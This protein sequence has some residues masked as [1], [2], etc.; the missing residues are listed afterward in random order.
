MGHVASTKGL[1]DADFDAESGT[2]SRLNNHGYSG[3]LKEESTGEECPICTEDILLRDLA[4]LDPCNH[5]FHQECI[6][7]WLE[8][9]S[10]CPN[11][12][13]EV[14]Q[15]IFNYKRCSLLEMDSTSRSQE[16][17]DEDEVDDDDDDDDDLNLELPL[18]SRAIQRQETQTEDE[19]E[20]DSI[21]ST[22]THTLDDFE[23]PVPVHVIIGEEVV[24]EDW[25]DL[26]E[27][28]DSQGHSGP[29]RVNIKISDDDWIYFSFYSKC[30]EILMQCTDPEL[31]WQI[32]HQDQHIATVPP[33][34]QLTLRGYF[35][36]HMEEIVI[37]ANG[38]NFPLKD[39]FE[40]QE[41]LKPSASYFD[42]QVIDIARHERIQMFMDYLRNHL[43][44]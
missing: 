40:F 8:D 5:E 28:R 31:T 14:V 11:C 27:L 20:G 37:R 38:I 22:L 35:F 6:N 10:T 43:V 12:R 44:A 19:E 4:K 15:V 2:S 34:G 32:F 39:D 13:Q 41:F 9:H 25:A 26:E 16:E 3:L 21:E 7:Q 29:E 1:S 42:S 33:N 23:M 36:L 24:N 18:G 30:P 17:E